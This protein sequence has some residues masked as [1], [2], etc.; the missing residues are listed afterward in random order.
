MIPTLSG[1][2]AIRSMVHTSNIN[3][4][5]S[6]N[7]AYFHSFI[8]YGIIFWGNSSNSGKIFTLQKQIIKIMADA[9]SR[10]TC[11]SPFKQLEILLLHASIYIQ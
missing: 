2:C 5:K 7:Y 3:T 8:R 6:I 1:E 9:Q 10:T 4:L 11:R